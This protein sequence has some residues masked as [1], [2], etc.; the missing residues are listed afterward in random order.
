M[1]ADNEFRRVAPSLTLLRN[2]PIFNGVADAQL[3]EIARIARQ[4]KVPRSTIIVRAGEATDALYVL[5]SGGAKVC[6]SDAEGREVILTLLGPGEF[7]GEMGLIDDSPRSADVVAEQPCELLVIAKADFKRCLAAD[8]DIALNIMKSL[9]RRLRQADRKIESLALM[10]VY[11]RVAKLLLDFS[12]L[13]SGVRVIR[14]KVTKQDMAKM[15]GASR[16]MVSRVMKDLE[17][18][19][20]IRVEP[21]RIVLNAD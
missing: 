10:D 12:E 9:V 2:I 13:E 7:F 1:Q 5:V 21:G 16:E 15:I 3:A 6:N 19:G 20:Y 8:S 14:R 11:G 4:R 17:I 18:A